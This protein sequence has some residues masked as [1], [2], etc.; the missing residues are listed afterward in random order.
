MKT[1]L[2]ICEY[3]PFHRGHKFQVEH[4]KKELGYSHVIALM[5]GNMV[6]RGDMAIFDK[7]FRAKIACENGC[8]VVFE[9]PYIYSGQTA[10]IFSRGAVMLMEKLGIVDSLCFGCEN[11]EQDKFHQ[12][13]NA[14]LNESDE[15]KAILKESLSKGT[16]FITARNKALCQTLD[17]DEEFLSTPN[18]ILG[19][20]YVKSLLETNSSVK[21]VPIKRKSAKHNDVGECDGFCSASH[22][23]ELLRGNRLD[24]IDKVLDEKIIKEYIGREMNSIENYAM[25]IASN[26]LLRGKDDLSSKLQLE[27]GLE[28]RIFDRL[29]LLNEGVEPFIQAVSTK[30]ITKSRIRRSLLN[31][32]LEVNKE[33]INS[34]KETPP[35]YI[36][37]LSFKQEGKEL[38]SKIK[39][40]STLQ[41]VSNPNKSRNDLSKRDV[42]LFA[43]ENKVDALYHLFNKKYT[44]DGKHR[45]TII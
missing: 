17:I 36:T 7:Y 5:S 12:V 11:D 35:D 39:S 24:E 14:L 6:Q 44:A 4:L 19:I 25:I 18:N 43:L 41:I 9:L 34:F 28:N 13:A 31:Y 15:F 3:N 38:L 23:R 27:I 37:L 45:P 32:L 22:L 21:V 26:L 42:E 10:E 33:S 40:K 30:R 8:D 29:N 2:I 20:E 1:A 16:S